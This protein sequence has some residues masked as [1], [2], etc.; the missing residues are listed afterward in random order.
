MR[1]NDFAERGKEDG[2]LAR[3]VRIVHTDKLLHGIYELRPLG[4]VLKRLQFRQPRSD[5][6]DAPPSL[7]FARA[8]L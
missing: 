6:C 4:F 1:R 2:V 8:A 7:M 3:L 5:V